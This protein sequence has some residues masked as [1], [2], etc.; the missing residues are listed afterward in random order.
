MNITPIRNVN[1]GFKSTKKLSSTPKTDQEA[2][3][4]FLAI[5]EQTR[6][7][8]VDCWDKLYGLSTEDKLKAA[9]FMKATYISV[10][11]YFEHELLN[12]VELSPTIDRLLRTDDILEE[13]EIE[14]LKEKM[15]GTFS[16]DKLSKFVRFRRDKE[17][18]LQGNLWFLKDLINDDPE[19]F[20]TADPMT[21]NKIFLNYLLTYEN[22]SDALE[23]IKDGDLLTPPNDIQYQRYS[24]TKQWQKMVIH[25]SLLGESY[26]KAAH[27]ANYYRGY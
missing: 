15:E 14:A 1:F 12:P 11:K 23:E 17:G 4:Y 9:D 20:E 26:Y 22:F 16:P 24:S 21:I 19:I 3:E 8:P 10:P 13:E 25:E 27:G 6:K 2:N 7:I 18:E 5:D